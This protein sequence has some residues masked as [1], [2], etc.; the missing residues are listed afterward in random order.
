[1]HDTLIGSTKV[2]KHIG[3]LPD[4]SSEFRMPTMPLYYTPN[5]SSPRPFQI[6]YGLYFHDDLGTFKNLSVATRVLRTEAYDRDHIA[7]FSFEVYHEGPFL[8]KLG[9][10]VQKMLP[11]QPPVTEV[12]VCL[13]CENCVP[14]LWPPPGSRSPEW[15]Y[16][17]T[18]K[19]RDG[20]FITFGDLQRAAV[21]KR[22]EHRKLCTK[23]RARSTVDL[24]MCGE[25]QI[26]L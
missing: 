22:T 13:R 23:P 5:S 20:K 14:G 16:P 10:R 3:L 9:P 25:V 15:W 4:P 1:M 6:F 26:S 17:T 21:C 18:I 19:P 8:Q 2:Q 24:R 11:F 7:A 12:E